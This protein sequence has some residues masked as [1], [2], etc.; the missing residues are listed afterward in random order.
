M[1]PF[2]MASCEPYCVAV[3][4]TPPHTYASTVFYG[5]KFDHETHRRALLFG[6]YASEAVAYTAMPLLEKLPPISAKLPNQ[7]RKVFHN[8]PTVYRALENCEIAKIFGSVV[9]L[10]VLVLTGFEPYP[11]SLCRMLVIT[12]NFWVAILD[13]MAIYF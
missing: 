11:A 2:M 9:K 13:L 8:S 7:N 12:G 6:F 10:V 3:G 1:I 4:L 5:F